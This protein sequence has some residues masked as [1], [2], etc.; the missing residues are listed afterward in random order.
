MES[1]KINAEMVDCHYFNRVYWLSDNVSNIGLSF[2]WTIN[3]QK[4]CLKTFND[5]KN[6]KP[7]KISKC[8]NLA[9]ERKMFKL[10]Q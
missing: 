2:Y 10:I 9:H 8:T 1:L 4:E 5:F 3:D 7:I 6:F